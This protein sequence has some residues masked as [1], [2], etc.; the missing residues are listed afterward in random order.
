MTSIDAENTIIYH[1]KY[2][3]FYAFMEQPR[4]LVAAQLHELPNKT[5]ESQQ[6]EKA[7][8][9][10]ARDRYS[11]AG[12]LAARMR[13]AGRDGFCFGSRMGR[14]RGERSPRE[15]ARLVAA[16][17]A[18]REGE[19]DALARGCMRAAICERSGSECEGVHSRRWA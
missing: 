10:R 15:K 19:Q 16:R 4:A 9:P 14:A 13:Q 1:S 5:E 3:V 11:S 12:M 8:C 6:T 7:S 2:N 17:A 18:R